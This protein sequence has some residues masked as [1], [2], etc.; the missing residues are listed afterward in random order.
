MRRALWISAMAALVFSLT[1]PALAKPIPGQNDGP[2]LA[3]PMSEADTLVD[4]I[5]ACAREVRHDVILGSK[6]K[7][8]SFEKDSHGRTIWQTVGTISAR[9]S[10]L[11]DVRRNLNYG[12]N[13]L[14]WLRYV[15]TVYVGIS[16]DG[17][18]NSL[19]IC[20]LHR[21]LTQ[22]TGA[23]EGIRRFIAVKSDAKAVRRH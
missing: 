8:T 15:Y 10:V 21:R 2:L 22:L 19:M 20:E 1:A 9:N 5:R 7:S 12:E 3:E 13:H 14:T 18:Q 6:G 16:T 11:D 23:P 4:V 17:N